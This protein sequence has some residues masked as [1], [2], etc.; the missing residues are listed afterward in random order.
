[1][2][3]FAKGIVGVRWNQAR[4]I[5]LDCPAQDHHISS[6]EERYS[7]LMQN[8]VP[9]NPFAVS[10]FKNGKRVKKVKR[11]GREA[12]EDCKVN[13]KCKHP[14]AYC[15]SPFEKRYSSHAKHSSTALFLLYPAKY[16]DSAKVREDLRGSA[17]FREEGPREL[18]VHTSRKNSPYQSRQKE[19]TIHF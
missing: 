15:I 11:E 5:V 10:F 16:H 17:R 9:H 13:K 7:L 18:F 1:V 19:R 4:A 6:F 14:F 3:L 8:I 2:Q 12:K